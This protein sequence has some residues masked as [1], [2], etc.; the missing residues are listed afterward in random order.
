MTSICRSPFRI[1]LSCREGQ[2]GNVA[3]PLDGRRQT[4]LVGRAHAGQTP[5]HNLASLRHK[6][7]QQSY[8]FVVDIVDFFDAESANLFAPEKLASLVAPRASGPATVA[9]I[10]TLAVTAPGL[11]TA[12][13]SW[14]FLIHFV[15]H[16]SP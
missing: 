5:R 9:A 11:R 6:L 7:L 12:R 2:Q 16:K 1:F 14:C 8:V 3:R 4:A 13:F 10:T 15:S